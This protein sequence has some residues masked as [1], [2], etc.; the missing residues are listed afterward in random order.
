[1]IKLI[2]FDLD[3]TLVDSSGDITNALNYAIAPGGRE[4]LT[5]EATK[6]LIGEGVTRLIEKVLGPAGN[7][8][9]RVVLE[10]FMEFYGDHL[11]DRTRAYPEV[12]ETLM[13]LSAYAKAVISNK[14]ESFS[15]KVLEELGLLGHFAVVFGSD[16]AREKKPS[17]E[18]LREVMRRLSCVP[19]EAVMVGDSSYDIQAGRSAGVLT[20]GVSYGYRPAD[21]LLQADI[22]IDR[23]GALREVLAGLD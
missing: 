9:M 13:D 5:V 10:R 20:I 23:F 2:M 15:K 4:P 19:G 12:P 7:E 14:R 21:S 3:G 16:S 17:P 1:M 6:N 18:P 22:V 11:V 8:E